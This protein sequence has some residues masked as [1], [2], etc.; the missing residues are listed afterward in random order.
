MRAESISKNARVA[1][2]DLADD[3]EQVG[4]IAFWRA[5]QTF[6]PVQGVPFEHYARSVIHRA[7][8]SEI[9]KTKHPFVAGR[10]LWIDDPNLDPG[11]LPAV[12]DPEVSHE[13]WTSRGLVH[14][15]MSKG[16]PRLRE[17]FCLLYAEDLTQ[18]Q[19]AVLLGISQ[20][21]ISQLHGDLLRRGRDE[22]T[23]EES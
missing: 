6:D 13:R 5:W 7:M 18:R 2:L 19:A 12:A 8:S 15:W 11:I 3:L 9:R 22:L 20:P 10:A 23:M 1:L 17:V 16:P 21:R 4:L 14:R